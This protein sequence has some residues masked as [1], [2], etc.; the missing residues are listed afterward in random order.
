M[1]LHRPE[2]SEVDG[3]ICVEAKVEVQ[4]R[5]Y[6]FPDRLWFRFPRDYQ[7]FVTD[8]ADGFA[9]ALLPLAMTLGEHMEIRGTLSP[10]LLH[11]MQ[12]YLK[13]Q[14]TWKPNQF[15]PIE[16][17]H[18][19]LKRPNPG[20]VRG[21]VGCAFSGGVDSFHTLWCR[22][23][24]NE[25]NPH[26]R[27]THCLTVN[28]FDPNS[29]LENSGRYHVITRAYEPMMERLGVR[30]LVSRTNIMQFIDQ[31]IL[32]QSFGAV[33]AS[34]ALVLGRLFSVFHI[35]SSY[36]FTDFYP[37]GS[38]PVM[39]SLM[40]T[41]T[42]DTTHDSPH[43]TR[44]EKTA[45]LA[46][47]EETFP[48][49]RV[50]FNATSFNEAT[51]AFENCCHCEKCLRTMV[52]LD[53]LGALSRYR[54]FP[55]G[56]KRSELRKCDYSYKGSLLFALDIVRHARSAGRR[57]VIF[58]SI[59]AVARGLAGRALR[60]PYNMVKTRSPRS[61]QAVLKMHPGQKR[62]TRMAKR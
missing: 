26:Y 62:F 32:K 1:I 58:D 16:I 18:D 9:A 8:R 57:D 6:P 59:C 19:V 37:D 34:S 25:P 60:I 51:Q 20:D 35:A 5:E 54:S 45:V 43:V 41:E 53:M 42:L 38:H 7:N 17:T 47:W 24:G 3:E 30:L 46:R 56:L 36:K 23:P 2:I 10:R 61:R 11:G 44:F 4:S 33:L 27:L 12:Q 49:L 31:W 50:C 40:S 39:D 22:L 28:G 21:A 13:I 52:S 48:L 55:Q 29:D 15:D 14:S